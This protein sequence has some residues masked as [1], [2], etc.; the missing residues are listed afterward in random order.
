MGVGNL[1]SLAAA[2]AEWGEA[3]G[4][5]PRSSQLGAAMEVARK[6]VPMMGIEWDGGA[7][8]PGEAGVAGAE[9]ARVVVK[10][11]S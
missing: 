10:Q 7:D 3:P 4:S 8:A 6:L 9:G 1:G 11:E 2:I 5:V